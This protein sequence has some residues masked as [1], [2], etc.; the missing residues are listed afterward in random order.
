MPVILADDFNVDVKDNYNAELVEFMK[1]TFELDVLSDL[2][3]GT[4]RCNSCSDMGF[5]RNLDNLSCMNY[6]SYFSYRR[7]ILSRT[8]LQA[9]Q[10]TDVTK[11]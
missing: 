5:G 11:S 10:L 9:P 2:S 4:T 6:V 7:P 1:D 3:Q 8:N